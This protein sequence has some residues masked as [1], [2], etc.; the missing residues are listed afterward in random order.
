VRSIRKDK[1]GF[2]PDDVDLH[3]IRC[4]AAMAMYLRTVPV[5]TIMLIGRWSS[6]AFL[7]YIRRQV[8]EFSTGVA[9]R[10]V[11]QPAFF[12]IPVAQTTMEDPHPPQPFPAL[13]VPLPMWLCDSVGAHCSNL[14]L[15]HMTLSVLSAAFRSIHWTASGREIE[16]WRSRF[17]AQEGVTLHL[18]DFCNAFI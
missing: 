13:V 1:L 9:S 4:G 17:A 10:M 7:L 15:V 12:T 11:L 6:D 18:A 16:P 8:Q 2:G 5:F 14:C 3:S